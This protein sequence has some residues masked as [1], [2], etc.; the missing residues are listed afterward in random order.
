MTEIGVLAK[1]KNWNGFTPFEGVTRMFMETGVQFRV[2]DLDMDYSHLPLVILPDDVRFTQEDARKFDAYLA[3]GGKA[4]VTGT[5]GLIAPEDTRD[6]SNGFFNNLNEGELISPLPTK[7]DVFAKGLGLKIAGVGA[8]QHAYFRVDSKWS[9]GHGDFAY[10]VP[11]RPLL[12]KPIGKTG[13]K[14]VLEMVAPYFDRS[15]EKYC[16]HCQT[17][18]DKPTG[19][20]TGFI[21]NQVA[22]FAYPLFT[23][24]REDGNAIYKKLILQ[25]LQSLKFRP[26]VESNLP[27]TAYT[28]LSRKEAATL[29]TVSHWIPEKRYRTLDSIEEALPLYDCSFSVQIAKKPASVVSLSSGRKIRFTYAKGRVQF[30]ADILD[31]FEMFKV[32]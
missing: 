17:P 22:Y 2:Y 18:A 19:Q 15:A 29:L 13:Y 24:Y 1:R 20:F 26:Q 31:G 32:Q 12:V 8:Y 16:G 14:T 11:H 9:K 7:A 4:I 6:T 27:S 3:A 28:V 23:L 5:S 30:S 21:S 25:A 10:Y